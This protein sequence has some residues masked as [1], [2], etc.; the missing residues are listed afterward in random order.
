M[1]IWAQPHDRFAMSELD[2][3]RVGS[4]DSDGPDG[5]SES[6]SFQTLISAEDLTQSN[7]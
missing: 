3:Y 7:K 6:L 1:G 4:D 2:A 5:I